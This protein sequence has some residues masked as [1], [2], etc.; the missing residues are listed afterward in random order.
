MQRSL[1]ACLETLNNAADVLTKGLSSA[2]NAREL[3]CI[4]EALSF[5]NEA[6]A[7]ITRGREAIKGLP[8]GQL[9]KP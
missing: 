7:A 9:N 2:R 3:A 5:V 6:Q 1:D 4:S 8:L